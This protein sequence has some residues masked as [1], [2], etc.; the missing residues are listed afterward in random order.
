MRSTT[1]RLLVA[2]AAL[3]W[4]LRTGTPSRVL[5]GTTSVQADVGRYKYASA[6]GYLVLEVLDDDLLHLQFGAAG[7]GPDATQPLSASPMV[8]KVDYS[9]PTRLT[10]KGNGLVETAALRVQVDPATLCA[11]VTDTL[12]DPELL[13]TTLCPRWVAAGRV[14]FTVAQQS[15]THIYGLGQQF[16]MPDSPD[17]D[18]TGRVRTPG[19]SFGNAMT[20]LDGGNAGNTQIPVA[21]FLGQ[22]SNA[23]ALFVDS[24]YAQKWDLRN[25]PWK[26]ET[27]GDPANNAGWST[28]PLRLYVLA[29]PDLLDLR[30]DYLELTG[31]PPVPP[32]KAFGLW[33]SEY[34]F[35]NWAELDDKLRTL[36]AN[37]FPV[38]GFV[39]DLQWYGGITAGAENTRMGSLTWDLDNFPDPQGKIASLRQNDGVGIMTIEQPYV[40][41]A[42]PEHQELAE[43]GYLVRD[44]ETCAPTVLDTNPWWGV[45][46]MID[47]TNDAAGAY[48]HDAKREPL[49]DAGVI[50]HWTDLGEPEQYNPEAWY[51]GVAL[52]GSVGHGEADVHNLYNLKWSQSVY[53]GSA[54][55]QDVQ[56]P[57]ILSRSGT[58]G[59]Q[60]YGVAMW[61]GDVASNLSTLATQFNTQMHMSFS[62]I[63]YYGADIG[64]FMRQ[65]GRGDL[66]TTYTQWFA[67]GMA[68]D[69]P[70]RAH[71]MNL[72]NCYETAPDRMGDLQSNLANV[73]QRYEL[74]PY[75]YSLAHRA[76][77][78]G[79]PVFPSLVFYYPEDPNVREMGGEKLIGRDLL[80]APVAAEGEKE[81]RVYLPAGEW[82]NYQSDEWV[83]SAGEWVGPLPLYVDKQYKLP[84]FARAGAIIP[85]MYVDDQTMN[86]LGQR[87]DGS[88]RDELI[89]RV[90]ASPPANPANPA[91]NAGRS[92]G[93]AGRST[94]NAGSSTE[95]RS[96]FTL[97]EDDGATIAYQ[98]GEVRTTVISQQLA[99]SRLAV[100]IAA[101]SGTYQGAPTQ[102]DNVVRLVVN[103]MAATA[104]TLNGA[105]LPQLAGP[106]EFDR[107]ASGWL[108][109]SANVIVAKSG[110]L[111]VGVAKVFGFSLALAEESP[112]PSQPS[113]QPQPTAP[114]QPVPRAAVSLWRWGLIVAVLVAIILA[115]LWVG[116]VYEKRRA[117]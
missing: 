27:S 4:L 41:Q 81:H 69:V 89:V 88:R 99:E 78:Y 108:N 19:N 49:I 12:K 72:C 42:L 24:P 17:G 7:T 14:G 33:V 98:K 20:P 66:D 32:K 75:L 84:L 40:G 67:E 45:G 63:D 46:G 30:Q 48:W 68:L 105:T 50:G 54:R 115:S 92:S 35:D 51:A 103:R 113:G 15:F 47:W 8:S 102:R 80:V 94:G 83:S 117:H 1:S 9:G 22:G 26:V 116:L 13:L 91:Q 5:C 23:Y 104:V 28:D 31:R 11:T 56:R 16:L 2:L 18:W 100:T 37:H 85:Q 87:A 112:S 34:G 21:Y 65:A 10:D 82:V 86:I 43:K 61:S 70:A 74:S 59:S 114:A 36:R 101:A 53:D 73:R 71:T 39:L 97:Y 79:E 57:F 6:D 55:N 3:A 90:Y 93:N 111:D 29:G 62:G 38:D 52:D 106:A 110:I 95:Q 76:Y 77:L 96:E 109:E 107:A 60:R 58:A 64:G 44:C 25:D